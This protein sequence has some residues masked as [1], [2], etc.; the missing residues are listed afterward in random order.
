MKLVK[1]LVMLCALVASLAGGYVAT[2]LVTAWTIR[3]AIK[4]GDSDYLEEKI[5]WTSVRS[6]LKESL[7]KFA[8][9]ASGEMKDQSVGVQVP[10]A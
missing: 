2:P 5:E 9:S 3:E 1:R 6:T 7:G 4:A 8:F 10:P